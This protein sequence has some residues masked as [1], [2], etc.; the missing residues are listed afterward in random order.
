MLPQKIAVIVLKCAS[1]ENSGYCA[2]MCSPE[3]SGF[4]CFFFTFFLKCAPRKIAAFF[5]FFFTFF[6][7]CAEKNI[8]HLLAITGSAVPKNCQYGAKILGCRA[9][10]LV[11]VNGVQ[12]IIN[13][14]G[15]CPISDK[16][17]RVACKREGVEQM[18]KQR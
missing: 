9:N 16:S 14:V 8:L 15:N 18:R 3:N 7:K 12:D 13:I 4:F 6:L 1:S 17:R 11:R 10:F 2:K 5:V